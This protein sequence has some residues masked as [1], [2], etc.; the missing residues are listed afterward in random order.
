MSSSPWVCPFCALHCDDLIVPKVDNEKISNNSLCEK[1]SGALSKFSPKSKGETYGYLFGKKEK[2]E[3]LIE[4]ISKLLSSSRSPFFGGLGLDIL[5]SRAVVKLAKKCN[6]TIDHM[7]GDTMSPVLS[8]LQAKGTIFTTLSEIKS[9]ADVVIFLKSEPGNRLPRF[10][11]IINLRNKKSWIINAKSFHGVESTDSVL[12]Q[13][14]SIVYLLRNKLIN[15]DNKDVHP[16]L[17][18]VNESSYSVFVWDPKNFG[19]LSEHIA[20]T[21]MELV[22]EVNKKKRAGILT[23]GSDSGGLS[24]QNTISWMTGKSIRSRFSNHSLNYQPEL[25]SLERC[26]E[27]R[28]ID[29][30]FW[31]SSFCDDL[32][33]AAQS[34]NPF[35]AFGPE[36][37]GKKYSEFFE[38]N[39]NSIFVPIS[40]PGV[41]SNGY[42]MRCDGAVISPFT[43]I[44]DDN[45]PTVEKLVF[46]IINNLKKE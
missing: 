5:G 2:N 17:N 41:N 27:L 40:T 26:L 4:G 35:V 25:F 42:I 18:L 29:S 31:F 16:V 1:S 6:A 30:I 22:K 38:V 20:N 19:L 34:N 32:P 39:K 45:L 14:R 11:E 28:T 24:F 7:H 43:K 46:K 12:E 10:A 13:I 23:L 9:R 3:T 21:L 8:S 36:S 37:M 44:I 33:N 15:P